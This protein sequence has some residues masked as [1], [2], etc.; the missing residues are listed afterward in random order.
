MARL[1]GLAES[2]LQS[3]H[4]IETYREAL[5]D[6]LEESERITKMLNILMDVS[7]AK[8]GTLGVDRELMDVGTL[9][10]EVVEVNSYIALGLL[11]GGT[12]Q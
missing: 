6:A 12:G 3:G 10:K 5:S 2:A 9:P 8:A 11:S 4:G 1:W 7:E